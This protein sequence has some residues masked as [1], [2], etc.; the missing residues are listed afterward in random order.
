MKK[1]REGALILA[2][3]VVMCFVAV[4]AAGMYLSFIVN[5]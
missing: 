1:Q 3:V 2:V 4:I 5:K